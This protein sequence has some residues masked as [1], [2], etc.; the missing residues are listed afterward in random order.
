MTKFKE[1]I[2]DFFDWAGYGLLIVVMFPVVFCALGF[3]I[4]L[5]TW[6]MV[7]AQETFGVVVGA[8]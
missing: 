8:C 4:Y 5:F 2:A 1:L 3:G 6:I 7:L